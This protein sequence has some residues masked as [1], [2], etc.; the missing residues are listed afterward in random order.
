MIALEHIRQSKYDDVVTEKRR[1]EAHSRYPK[2]AEYWKL[3]RLNHMVSG[4][5]RLRLLYHSWCS[6]SENV[7]P[8][9]LYNLVILRPL[10]LDG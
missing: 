1:S 9:R 8:G 2:C 7:Y 4:S 3:P 5:K 10:D 6:I